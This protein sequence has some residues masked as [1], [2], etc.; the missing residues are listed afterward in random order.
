MET[1]PKPTFVR[2]INKQVLNYVT[3][4]RISPCGISDFKVIGPVKCN[5]NYVIAKRLFLGAMG[6]FLHMF[7]IDA[8][9]SV[10]LSVP[11]S[12][13]RKLQG[14]YVNKTK[15]NFISLQKVVN[16]NAFFVLRST[17]TKYIY[18]NSNNKINHF[19][20]SRT[21]VNC[22]LGEDNFHHTVSLISQY[23]QKTN[24]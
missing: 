14:F 3:D 4:R 24:A 11:T 12:H 15:P 22:W 8:K 17:S 2:F 5:E 10:V 20:V 1:V 16:I 6:W 19:D 13:V 9:C 18:Y 7:V 23:L 21:R